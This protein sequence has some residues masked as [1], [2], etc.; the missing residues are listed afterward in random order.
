MDNQQNIPFS[1]NE[2]NPK[3]CVE[4]QA[5]SPNR[6]FAPVHNP[7][8]KPYAEHQEFS[9]N[10][11]VNPAN[12][13]VDYPP[14]F[15]PGYKPPKKK[16]EKKGTGKKIFKAFYSFVLIAKQIAGFMKKL[17]STISLSLFPKFSIFDEVIS[18]SNNSTPL[19]SSFVILS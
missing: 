5:F 3:P 14:Y 13:P 17:S 9:T 11:P 18:S 16:M 2:F 10:Q 19:L 7:D 12:E 6:P 8:P 15:V 4:P 1:G